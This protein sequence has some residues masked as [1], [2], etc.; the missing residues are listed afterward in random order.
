VPELFVLRV[1]CGPGGS[2]GN[3][4]GVVLDGR[5]I[6]R[7]RRQEVAAELGFSETVFVD[8]P[9]S[10]R[11]AIHTPAVE[12]DFAGHPSVG[13]AWLLAERGAPVE[14]LRPPAGEIAVR[15]EAEGPMVAAR[16]E[17]GPPFEHRQLDTPAEVDVLAVPPGGDDLVAAWA[18]IDEEAGL[19]RARVFAGRLGIPEDEATGTAAVK[20]GGLLGRDLDIRQGRGSR[21]LV[22]PLPD[23]RVEV[24]GRVELDEVRSGS[25]QAR[26]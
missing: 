3:H 2:A 14:V 15:M 8:D 21:L 23:G 4:L 1:F 6:P 12:L 5:E 11:I 7:N 18:W 25:W 20:L 13:T 26:A 9:R 22:H 24:G 10:G 16:P 19:V 17:W